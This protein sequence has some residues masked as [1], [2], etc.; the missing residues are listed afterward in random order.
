MLRDVKKITSLI[1]LAIIELGSRKQSCWNNIQHG[2]LFS[3]FSRKKDLPMQLGLCFLSKHL[4]GIRGKL[5][6]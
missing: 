2:Q 3:F 4:C 1:L 5:I 6:D